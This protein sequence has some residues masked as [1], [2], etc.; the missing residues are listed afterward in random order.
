MHVTDGTLSGSSSPVTVGAGPFAGLQILLPGETSVP[1]SPTGRTGTPTDQ[2]A[3]V[4]FSVTVDSVDA[5]WNL[6][7]ATGTVAITSSDSR[8][9]L[10]AIG[11]LVNGS[12]TLVAT[13]ESSGP[14]TLTATDVSDVTKTADTSSSVNCADTAPTAA[15]DGYEMTADQTLD[16]PAAGVLANDTDPDGQPVSVG[17][18]RPTSGPSHGTVTLNADGS[19]EYTPSAGFTGTD[20]FEYA[21][22]DGSLNSS[23][24]TVSIVVRDHSMISAAGW[25]TTFSPASYLVLAF[26]AYVPSGAIVSGATFHFSYRS[27]DAA[28]ATCL[29][30]ELYSA[31]VLIGSHGSAVAPASCNST[32]AYVEAAITLSEVNSVAVANDLTVRVYMSN[33]AGARSQVNLGSLAL[34]WDLP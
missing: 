11:A 4:A 25:P 28:G 2:H 5:Y 30:I 18:P 33:S 14:Q 24:A 10:P 1:G 19:F 6:I 16:V 7:P 21:A 31:G 3:N 13:L 9:L 23:P 15:D 27:L 32:T 8:A 17:L 12:A 20:S 26:P 29:Y 34:D 22:S